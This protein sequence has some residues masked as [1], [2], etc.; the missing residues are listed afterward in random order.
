M[1]GLPAG[2]GPVSSGPA[3]NDTGTGGNVNC[4][5][6]GAICAFR[7][8]EEEVNGRGPGSI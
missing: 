5:A 1:G 8:V 7:V 3:S 2:D 6:S 4:S